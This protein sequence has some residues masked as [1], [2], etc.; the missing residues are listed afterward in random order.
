[1]GMQKAKARA[2]AKQ[3]QQTVQGLKLWLQPMPTDSADS[4]SG[5]LCAVE[6]CLQVLECL[7]MRTIY[8]LQFT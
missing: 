1:M 3:C 5:P 4:Q 2:Q 7:E 6:L 8:N